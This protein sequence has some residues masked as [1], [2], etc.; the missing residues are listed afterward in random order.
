MEDVN[1]S[2]QIV[3]VFDATEPKESWNIVSEHVKHYLYTHGISINKGNLL[4]SSSK[5]K[6]DC[7]QGIFS[8]QYGEVKVKRDGT[9]GHKYWLLEISDGEEINIYDDGNITFCDKPVYKARRW[10]S[11]Y[12]TYITTMLT[13]NCAS[14]EYE[15]RYF[16]TMCDDTLT[17]CRSTDVS[18]ARLDI[19][20]DDFG[21]IEI[22]LFY[23]DRNTD[24]AKKHS[25][26]IGDCVYP[27][28]EYI[29]MLNDSIFDEK[30]PIEE[31]EWMK[32]LF[33]DPRLSALLG[34]L[35]KKIPASKEEWY[36]R[37][38]GIIDRKHSTIMTK[39]FNLFDMAKT[40]LQKR[41]DDRVERIKTLY[42]KKCSL[43]DAKME[44][45]EARLDKDSKQD[46]GRPRLVKVVDSI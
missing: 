39:E 20:W 27:V 21:N 44:K 34:D 42:S 15:K 22:E 18:S 13:K 23:K 35:L 12:F 28:E 9:T 19:R 40:E 36:N 30:V 5:K 6:I 25:V 29:K 10:K 45:L 4:N 1:D 11:E 7:Y 8:C 32:A 14:F 24:F 37:E 17:D 41:H 43:L 31:Q 16:E 3:Y 2:R 33:S 46:E 38:R 26:L